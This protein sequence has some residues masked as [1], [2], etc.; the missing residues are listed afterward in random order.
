MAQNNRRTP[1]SPRPAAFASL[2]VV[3]TGLIGGSFAKAAGSRKLFAEVVGLDRDPK[4]AAAALALGLVDRVAQAVPA[5]ADAVLLA[6]P[7]DQVAPWVCELADHPGILFDAGGVKAPIIKAVRKRHRQL[8]PRFVPCHPIAGSERSGPA[9]A[10][11]ELFAGANVILTPEAETDPAA[12]DAVN[13]WW[14]AV[15]ATPESM[16]AADHD[17]IL[18]VTSHLPHLLAFAYLEQVAPRH[19][20]HAGPGFR[21]FTRIGAGNPELWAAVLRL[22]RAPLLAALQSAKK[23][24]QRLED[25]LA[26]ESADS[27]TAM[28]AAAADKRRSLNHG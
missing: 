15:G 11:C 19:L 20:S 17:D 14:R 3:G 10:D 24:M 4:R 8:P 26:E 16:S 25:A 5:Q 22:N 18:A 27:L 12:V 9:A 13:G 1:A 21:D 7:A 2:A 28:I 23:S 6:T